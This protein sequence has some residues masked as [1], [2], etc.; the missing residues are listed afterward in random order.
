[1]S[2]E[3]RLQSFELRD[4]TILGSESVS[5][6]TLREGLSSPAKKHQ[7]EL[8]EK[9]LTSRAIER[10]N[11]TKHTVLERGV[12]RIL[13]GYRDLNE[14]AELFENLSLD[15][16]RTE[17]EKL[18]EDNQK[19]HCRELNLLSLSGLSK[20]AERELYRYKR[21]HQ[22]VLL[23]FYRIRP[24]LGFSAERMAADVLESASKTIRAALRQTD[25]PAYI[26]QA[27]FAVVYAPLKKKYAKKVTRR[28][29]ERIKANAY[30]D[31]KLDIDVECAYIPY[32]G[33]TLKSYIDGFSEKFSK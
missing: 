14:I 27:V 23:A 25:L 33:G 20:E 1:M 29:M 28:M 6:F 15:Q 32:T 9:N 19:N 16:V 2:G 22:P 30:L 18:W 7:I 10:L 24:P 3:N 8:S 12:W 26:D 11:I 4:F 31:L 17:K 5:G 21:Y 13:L